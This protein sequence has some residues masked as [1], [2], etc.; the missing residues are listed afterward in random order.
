MPSVSSS[1]V[2]HNGQQNFP[3][4]SKLPGTLSVLSCFLRLNMIKSLPLFTPINVRKILLFVVVDNSFRNY[5]LQL[6]LF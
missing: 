5:L 6:M 4:E 2:P 1:V 3:F